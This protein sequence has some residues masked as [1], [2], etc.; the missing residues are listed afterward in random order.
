MKRILIY[1][2]L[3]PTLFVVIASLY[4]NFVLDTPLVRSHEAAAEQ[5]E[6]AANESEKA[7]DEEQRRKL[8]AQPLSTSSFEATV[9]QTYKEKNAKL[10]Q[11]AKRKF[12]ED[13]DELK[14]LLPQIEKTTKQLN[15]LRARKELCNQGSN[16][17]S[18]D[19]CSHLET[20]FLQIM[21]SSRPELDQMDKIQAQDKIYLCILGSKDPQSECR[22]KVNFAK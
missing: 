18:G 22:K 13:G 19:E 9:E 16:A 2:F 12:L 7:F 5:A 20:D 21:Q 4:K 10:V 15:D 17:I 1:I 8:Q 3:V 11:Y 6:R 14:V